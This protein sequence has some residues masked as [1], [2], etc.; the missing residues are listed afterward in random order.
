MN[1]IGIAG[2][3]GSGKDTIAHFLSEKHGYYSATA[4]DM[5]GSELEQQGLPTDRQHKRELSAKWR[6][7]SG[8]G[9]LVD[10]AVQQAKTE[11]SDKLV[12]GSLRHPGEVDRVH[13][14]G[15]QV[16]WVDADPKIR[17]ERIRT[18]NRG[19][20]EDDKTFEEFLKEEQDEMSQQ[21]D[22]ATLHVAA[23]KDKADVFIDNN[24]ATID[25]FMSSIEKDLKEVI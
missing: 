6:R 20:I 16:I 14:L 22:A 19:R 18:N 15:G 8:M 25:E 17:Y 3:N 21:G 13:E 4:T 24:F 11:G 7:E 23:V 2:T 9:V 5:L 10:K 1:I 12:V